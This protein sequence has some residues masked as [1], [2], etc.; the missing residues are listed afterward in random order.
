MWIKHHCLYLGGGVSPNILEKFYYS[1]RAFLL[2]KFD[3]HAMYL[4]IH[5]SSFF[6][7]YNILFSVWKLVIMV[8][9]VSAHKVSQILW[10]QG[11]C[12]YNNP[13][14]ACYGRWRHAWGSGFVRKHNDV[15][16]LQCMPGSGFNYT[17]AQT[18]TPVYGGQQIQQSLEGWQVMVAFIRKL[19]QV[20]LLNAFIK[21][22]STALMPEC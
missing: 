9:I 2:Q 1:K 21:Q 19:W 13:V 14:T 7:L 15:A 11:K 6:F 5:L 4:T 3:Q 18:R 22:I 8:I 12:Y 16:G 20:V 17:S 10:W